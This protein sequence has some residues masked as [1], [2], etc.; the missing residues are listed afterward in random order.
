M[1]VIDNTVPLLKRLIAAQNPAEGDRIRIQLLKDREALIDYAM[2]GPVLFLREAAVDVLDQEIAAAVDI[3]EAM[4]EDYIGPEEGGVSARECVIEND[5]CRIHMVPEP[6][7][8]RRA[9]QFV[10]KHEEKD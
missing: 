6:C 8:V 5:Y 10:E 9:I 3:F 4:I 2:H 1:R 7:F